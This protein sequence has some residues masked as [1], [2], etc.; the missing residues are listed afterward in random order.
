MVGANISPCL[1]RRRKMDKMNEKEIEQEM[2]KY[3]C[4]Y[5]QMKE[6]RLGLESG[7]D[8]TKYADPQ[9]DFD[10]MREIR[11]GLEDGLDVSKYADPKFGFME[12]GE[13]KYGLKKGIDI[14]KYADPKFDWYQMSKIVD[15]LIKE[16][17]IK[18][19]NDRSN[20]N[21]QIS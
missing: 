21:W 13:I 12:M 8:V 15:N 11:T 10:Q 6:I 4:N 7:I 20:N 5:L 1:E 19:R 3:K 14:T 2:K 16:K 18:G 9:F 17:N